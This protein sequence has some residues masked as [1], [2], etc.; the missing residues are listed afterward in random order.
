MIM[1]DLNNYVIKNSTSSKIDNTLTFAK[2]ARIL[3][4]DEKFIA[5]IRYMK[6]QMVI[7]TELYMS[8]TMRFQYGVK[9]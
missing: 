2:I 1:Q 4:T 5:Q 3:V 7:N 8:V 6:K 9:P